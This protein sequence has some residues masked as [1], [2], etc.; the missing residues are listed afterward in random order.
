MLKFELDR[1][2]DVLV[3]EGSL[4]ERTYELVE[5]ADRAGL[6]HDLVRGACAQNP[7]NPLLQ[8]L[9]A[10]VTT[11]MAVAEAP[12]AGAAP[13]QGLRFFDVQDA[14]RFFGRA[15]LTDELLQML[16]SR[17]FLVIVGA[18]GSGK[19]SLARAGLIPALQAGGTIAGSERWLYHWL[20][21]TAHPIKA[22]AAR[23]TAAEQSVTAQATLM[24]DLYKESRSLDL[25]AQRLAAAAG[26]PRLFLL[27]DQFEEVFTLCSDKNERNAYIANL[28]TA[29]APDGLTTVVLTLRADFYAA[30]AEYDA[31]RA[32]LEQNQKYIG[33]MTRSEL[34]QAIEEPA[35]RGQWDFEDGLVEQLLRDA[36][37]GS[38]EERPEPSALPLLSHALLETWKRRNGRSLTFAGYAAA[39]G[40][41]GAIAQT[42]ESV[43]RE[44]LSAEEQQIARRIFLRLV[45]VG[46]GVQETRRRA[47]LEELYPKTH[48]D[49]AAAQQANAEARAAA[50]RV[51][52]KLASARL[53]TTDRD[54]VEIAHEALIREWPT[55][56]EWL[57]EDREEL[58]LHRRLTQAVDEWFASGGDGEP[59]K[60]PRDATLL[61]EGARLAFAENW[62]AANQDEL[63]EREEQFLQA[64]RR[65]ADAAARGRRNRRLILGGA[66]A[67]VLVLA[68]AALLLGVQ[69][70]RQAGDIASRRL[71]GFARNN[72]AVD[73]QLSVLL[74]VEAMQRAPTEEAEEVLRQA[75]RQSRLIQRRTASGEQPLVRTVFSPDHQAVALLSQEGSVTVRAVPTGTLLFALPPTETYVSVAFAPKTSGLLATGSMS[76]SVQLWDIPNGREQMQFSVSPQ[77]TLVTSLAFSPNEALLATGGYDYAVRLWSLAADQAGKPALLQEVTHQSPPLNLAFH[78]LGELLAVGTSSGTLHI[79]DLQLQDATA[80]WQGHK[81]LVLDLVFSP[82][83][84]SLASVGQEGQ[85]KVWDTR[86]LSLPFLPVRQQSSNTKLND[87]AF[88]TD[89]SCLAAGGSDQAITVW[90]LISDQTTLL[91]GA[92]HAIVGVDLFTD[93]ASAAETTPRRGCNGHLT[94]IG[95]D[96][97]LLLWNIGAAAEYISL[98][99]SAGRLQAVAVDPNLHW[100]A[101][102]DDQ[103]ELLI[104]LDGWMDSGTTQPLRKQLHTGEIN[105]LAASLDGRYLVSA[106]KDGAAHI[107]DT[108]T[109]EVVHSTAPIPAANGRLAAILAVAFPPQP[110]GDAVFATAQDDGSVTL[111]QASS[112]LALKHWSI[113]HGT[114]PAVN[115]IAF[116]HD[117]SRLLTGDADGSAYL[118]DVEQETVVLPLL[119]KDRAGVYGV[120]L[121]PDERYAYTGDSL[122]HLHIWRLDADDVTVVA[123]K[124]AHQ[125]HMTALEFSAD[126]QYFATSGMDGQVILWDSITQ[127]PLQIFHSSR[128]AVT[129]IRFAA[130][131]GMPVLVATDVTPEVNFYLIQQAD[132]V[133]YAGKRIQGVRTLTADECVRY[134]DKSECPP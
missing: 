59:P 116:N 93:E 11:W 67:I 119:S 101:A 109:W 44:Q 66:L 98:A 18:S 1:D 55:L 102:A 124:E 118:W 76:G 27:I 114:N 110:A 30:C 25:I 100:I 7:S 85:L 36:G 95:A 129:D 75:L 61:W 82:S 21:P 83:G 47:R 33:A 72:L 130:S 2:L 37:A 5:W 125:G 29:S 62:A 13:Y 26:A 134:L 126:G 56:R 104:W 107:L 63:S 16:R 99:P 89:G 81:D 43:Y 133:T 112:G 41:S 58:R 132:L 121:S 80:G 4:A 32:L 111:W 17:Q 68:T 91:N 131:R 57:D 90:D 39:G 6:V 19:S 45:T 52:D 128:N 49:D 74:A 14:D 113:H 8:T 87:L 115:R 42:A 46:D 117:G 3:V 92:N 9:A 28:L 127:T 48:A 54:D 120:A 86:D 31:L 105:D 12:Q 96:S 70:L 15:Q 69:S 65:Q 108:S 53:I 122:G 88:S 78:P 60:P 73:P 123:V 34:R 40:V 35:R 24:D 71:A 84:E 50:A 38:E 79:T 106:G 20:T 23:L 97:S 77:E 10:D 22:L 51:R 64:A 94:S 103:G